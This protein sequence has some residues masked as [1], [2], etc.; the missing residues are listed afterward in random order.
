MVT[1]SPKLV[2]VRCVK[3]GTP[4]LQTTD[5]VPSDRERLCIPC[6]RAWEWLP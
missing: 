6:A 3:C 4:L 2:I 5:L 1:D